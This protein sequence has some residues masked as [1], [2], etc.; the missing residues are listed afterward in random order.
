MNAPERRGEKIRDVGTRA[1]LFAQSTVHTAQKV[2][3]QQECRNPTEKSSV[4]GLAFG[5][6]RSRK[7]GEVCSLGLG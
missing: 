5:D 1:S 4:N 6:E 7:R 2:T 3:R